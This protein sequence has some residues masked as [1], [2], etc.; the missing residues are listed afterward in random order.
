MRLRSG[1]VKP[2]YNYALIA[3]R[4]IAKE[5]SPL[6]ARQSQSAQS[7]LR[8]SQ[9]AAESAIPDGLQKARAFATRLAQ[10]DLRNARAMSA[11]TA[12]TDIAP[13]I[14]HIDAARE[15][16][17]QSEAMRKRTVTDIATGE[18]FDRVLEQYHFLGTED[19]TPDGRITHAF[20]VRI[21]KK[22][23]KSEIR[24]KP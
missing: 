7:L 1:T 22:A 8:Q 14:Q 21:M 5:L 20:V 18:V 6:L 17:L 4:V 9:S 2:T 13:T 10:Q 24:D 15:H 12:R 11:R 19:L 23:L 3:A 16:I